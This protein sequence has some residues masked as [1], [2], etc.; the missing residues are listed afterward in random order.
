[1]SIFAIADLHLSG[2]P[3]CKPMDRFS[4]VWG[5]HWQKIQTA[6]L[7]S[8][9]P[10]DTVLI[11]GDISWALK[12][13]GAKQDLLSIA[14]L[15]GRKILLRGNHDYWWSTVGKMQKDDVDVRIGQTSLPNDSFH[16]SHLFDVR[17]P[18]RVVIHGGLFKPEI[19]RPVT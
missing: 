6:W 8:V 15:P 19:N 13:H 5:N 3:P 2:D 17:K 9:T 7:S 16:S 1:M 11:A 4:P 14:K 10:V 12:W 18:I